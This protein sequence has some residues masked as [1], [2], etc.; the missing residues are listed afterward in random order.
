MTLCFQLHLSSFLGL[1]LVQLCVVLSVGV[2]VYSLT[3]VMAA[4]F[5]TM[6][7]CTVVV[8]TICFYTSLWALY[9]YSPP[10]MVNRCRQCSNALWICKVIQRFS[11]H[12]DAFSVISVCFVLL[13]RCWNMCGFL[14][15]LSG[16][17]IPVQGELIGAT[18]VSLW[19][20][21]YFSLSLVTQRLPLDLEHFSSVRSDLA[22]QDSLNSKFLVSLTNVGSVG[23]YNLKVFTVGTHHELTNTYQCVGFDANRS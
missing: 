2:T 6:T 5:L 22:V 17:T 1:L 16:N 9:L 3:T 8:C 15:S 14:V 18:Q 13:H 21:C 7:V 4:L 19:L 20:P 10:G 11:E 12:D 23:L